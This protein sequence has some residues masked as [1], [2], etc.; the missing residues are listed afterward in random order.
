[1]AA[2]EGS[3]TLAVSGT[4]ENVAPV[5]EQ[6]SL[7]V[8]IID[9]EGVAWGWSAG[10]NSTGDRTMPYILGGE[11][12]HFT[13]DV[14]DAN[15]EADLAAM[16]VRVNLSPDISFNGSLV[17]TAID[18]D[19]GISRGSYSGNLTV[20]EGIAPGKYDIS[21]DATDP[22]GATDTYNPAIYEPNADILKPALSLEVGV[23]TVLFPQS[24]PGDLGIAANDNPVRLTPQAVIGNE[25]I[26]VVFSISHSGTDMVDGSNV[27]PVSS[28]VWSTTNQIT[29][30][31]LSSASQIIASAVEE[32]DTIEVYYWLN[33]PSPQEA[34]NY[35]GSIDFQ[36]LAD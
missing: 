13:L 20:D 28:I 31:S 8:Q 30:N 15:G 35:A 14:T 27:I 26:P 32:G 16:Q 3:G 21:I 34:G 36:F 2:D 24:N 25:H 29:D 10:G 12:L 6:G 7:V 22:A 17:S 33:V 9:N 18:P 11:Q 19:N 1:M 4:V 23:P 5:I